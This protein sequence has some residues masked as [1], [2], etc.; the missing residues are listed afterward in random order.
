MV[1]NIPHYIEHTLL[2]PLATISDIEN[3]CAE[4]KQFFFHGVCVPPVY[5]KL[6]SELLID[7]PQK[8]ISVV[9]FPLGYNSIRCKSFEIEDLIVNGV[10]EVDFVLNKCNVVNEDWTS[11]HNEILKLTE[12]VHNG[13]LHI[14]CIF[15]TSVLSESQIIILCNICEKTGVDFV[16]TSTGFVGQGVSKSVVR[17][18][19]NKL[20]DR[21]KIKASGG[22]ASYEEAKSLI[23][24]GADRL[25]CSKSIKI[26]TNE[27][28]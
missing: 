12:L 23:E 20:T 5:V 26:I 16:K 15:E 9:G 1:I 24:L 27:K 17:L 4:A 13:G 25:G 6:A 22:I 11:V 2:N 10:D 14:K 18:I 21:I 7:S 28:R 8:V 3:L 19:R